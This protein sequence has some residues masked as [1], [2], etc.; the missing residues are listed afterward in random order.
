MISHLVIKNMAIVDEIILDFKQ[1][2]TVLTGE[3]GAG[4]SIIIDSISL[5]LGE[6]A[7]ADI[8]RHGEDKAVIEGV[9]DVDYKPEIVQFLETNDIDYEIDESL[10]IKRIIKSTGGSQIRINGALASLTQLK[11]LGNMLVD[12]HVQHDSFRLFTPEKYPDIIDNLVQ[13]DKI[14]KLKNNYYEAIVQYK[15]D[16]KNLNAFNEVAK[17]STSR[18]FTIQS[19]LK[20]LEAAELVEGEEEELLYKKNLIVASDDI[21]TIYA[22]ILEST[23]NRDG[24][25][26]LIYPVLD[27]MEDLIEIN[28]K[29]IEL[30]TQ[31]K[32]IY[33]NLEDFNQ[34]IQKEQA[35]LDYDPRELEDIDNRL[36][37]LKRLGRKFQMDTYEMIEYLQEIRNERDELENLDNKIDEL[38]LKLQISYDL[39]LSTGETLNEA[40]VQIARRVEEALVKELRDLKL[41]NAQFE[42]GFKRSV[43]D[44]ITKN[45][46]SINGLY[47]IDMYL[48]TNRGEPL[49]PINK[50]ASGGELSRIMLGL[51]SILIR[52][53][54]LGTIIFDEIDT[55]VSGQVATSIGAKMQEIASFKQVFCITH[56]PQVAS[57]AHYHLHVTKIEKNNR[58]ATQVKYL[59]REERVHEIAVMMSDEVV[60]E[61]S[62]KNAREMLKSKGDKHG[63]EN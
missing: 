46:F 22:E 21:N 3:T 43:S 59:T 13:N 18:L 54:A 31:I 37:V 5:L 7:K 51:K 14:I 8:I 50:V 34:T 26:D 23:E 52:G 32:D 63:S 29:L 1:N 15:K 57:Y 30:Q 27:L 12:V 2:M 20:D 45:S 28:P 40:R 9:F 62:L 25:L 11:Q 39:V 4:K 61:A 53:Q 16:L 6:R 24:A 41:P 42:I 55:G 56:L 19:E 60:T 35:R 58:T 44:D 33:Y 49:K 47:D 38:T 17:H 36:S 10:I 48:S